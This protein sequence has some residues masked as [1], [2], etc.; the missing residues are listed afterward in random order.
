M[1]VLV[2]LNGYSYYLF[3][4]DKQLA[5]RG[6]YRLSEKRLVLASLCLGGVGALLAMRVAR[7]KTKHRLFQVVVP[8]SALLTVCVAVYL[9]VHLLDYLMYKGMIGL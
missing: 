7:H 2:A 6:S 5:R 4:K 9:L 3:V 1:L 8:M